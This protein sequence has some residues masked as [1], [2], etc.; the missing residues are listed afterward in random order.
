MLTSASQL[1][2]YANFLRCDAGHM[3]FVCAR[4]HLGMKKHTPLLL[5]SSCAGVWLA[6]MAFAVV[7]HGL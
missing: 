1:T 2:D 6:A 3:S 7:A 4:P 5:S